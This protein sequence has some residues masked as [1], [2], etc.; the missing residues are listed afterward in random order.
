MTNATAAKILFERCAR[1]MV[2]LAMEYLGFVS[3]LFSV[4][5]SSLQRP[6]ASD[7]SVADSAAGGDVL[8]EQENPQSKWLTDTHWPKPESFQLSPLLL[9]WTPFFALFSSCFQSSLP[10]TAVGKRKVDEHSFR[11]SRFGA[12]TPGPK[13]PGHD[14]QT[15]IAKRQ[16]ASVNNTAPAADM[17]CTIVGKPPRLHNSGRLDSGWRI[18]FSTIKVRASFRRCGAFTWATEWCEA[19]VKMTMTT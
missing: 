4:R 19:T 15:T 9:C 16:H 7:V 3:L 10:F 14:R 17:H 13:A 8:V 1:G 11:M 5:S 2:S 18:T 12:T 6:S